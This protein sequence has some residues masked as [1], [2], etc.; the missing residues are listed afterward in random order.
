MKILLDHPQPF[1]FAHGGVQ[2]QI[3][4]TKVALEEHGI[5]V[6]FLRWWD[7][8]QLGDLIHYF[9]VASSGYLHLASN[10]RKP[11]VMTSLFSE[12]CN[13]SEL[14]LKL[15]GQF[16]RWILRLPFGEGIKRQLTWRA[17]NYCACNIVGLKIEQKVLQTVYNVPQDKI[18]IVPLGLSE[19]F[20]QGGH[21]KQ[22]LQ[23]LICTGTINKVKQS[24]DLARMAHAA[25][26]PI[27][28]VGKPYH[29]ED[30]Y[31]HEFK[32]QIDEK[33]VKYKPHVDEEGEL[34]D[35]LRNSKGFVLFSKYEN[36]S[37]AAHEAAACG[38]P[39]L[40]PDKKWA[41]ERFGGQASYFT[42]D[43][44]RDIGVLQKFYACSEK[45][46]PPNVKLWSWKEAVL[47][48]IE[49]YKR[50]LVNSR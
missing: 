19:A 34:I 13:R 36:W 16:T 14:K 6:E 49:I 41:R 10:A 24:V 50:V 18:A 3:Q 23:H 27:L 26:V 31:W 30:S 37:L 28:F 32:Q 20:L 35:L 15:Q 7:A 1:Q 38:L 9:T 40:L 8:D 46:K 4:N 21:A 43:P 2:A 48:L 12:T 29:P 44:Q 33:V 45:A 22:K 11:V 5:E 25:G 47:P 39:L 17:Y 42:G